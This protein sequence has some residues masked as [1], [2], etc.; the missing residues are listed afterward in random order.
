MRPDDQQQRG[1]AQRELAPEVGQRF[2]IERVG[3][4]EDVVSPHREDVRDEQ[5][6]YREAERD[7]GGFPKRHPPGR[8][9]RDLDKV[10]HEVR[11]KRAAQYESADGGSRH[12]HAPCLDRL[13]DIDAQDSERMVQE[14]RQHEREK[15]QAGANAQ[16]LRERPAK[17]RR[18]RRG[19][20]GGGQT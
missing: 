13:H 20:S 19:Q 16:P 5:H 6:R 12:R 8:A 11:C 4:V 7:L 1:L 10:Q 2:R 18:S 17:E 14:M 9:S 3:A 15:D